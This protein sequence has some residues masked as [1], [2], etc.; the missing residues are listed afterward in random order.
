MN[1]VNIHQEKLH[2]DHSMSCE[3][4]LFLVGQTMDLPSYLQQN[5]SSDHHNIDNE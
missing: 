3:Y 5:V 1:D 4:K 2:P